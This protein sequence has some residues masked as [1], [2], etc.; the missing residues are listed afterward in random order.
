MAN[1]LLQVKHFY[2]THDEY[3]QAFMNLDPIHPFPNGCGAWR[4][5]RNIIPSLATLNRL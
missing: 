5:E 1:P 4:C 3:F 2:R